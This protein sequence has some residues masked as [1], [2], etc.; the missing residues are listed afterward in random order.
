MRPARRHGR[1]PS[2]FE[3]GTWPAAV[4]LGRGQSGLSAGSDSLS[5]ARRMR[6]FIGCSP[7][8]CAGGWPRRLPGVDVTRR[9]PAAGRGAADADYAA[10]FDRLFGQGRSAVLSGAHYRD[11]PPVDGGR[12][13]LSVVFL[14]DSD[15]MDRLAALT[16]EAMDIA[17]GEHWPTGAP[18]AVHFTVRAIQ[19]H[20]CAVQPDDP[21][22]FRCA[23]ALRRAA[24]GA[25]PVRLR[26]AG[27]TLTPSGVMACAVPKDGAADAFAARLGDELGDDGWFEAQ[28][29]RDIWYAT[30]LHFTS[31]IADRQGL[32][33]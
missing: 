7:P 8:L 19:V 2:S 27:L 4:A 17:G 24:A 3:P 16:A 29:H 33:D 26:L 32:V 10:V 20:R 22:E 9:P 28:F 23:A 11:T 1:P 18:H 13:G 14:P 30:L 12:W 31:D 15:A 5:A 6:D 25:R 21:L